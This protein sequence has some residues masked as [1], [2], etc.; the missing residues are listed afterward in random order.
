MSI[1][2]AE[3]T[4]RGELL[5]QAKQCVC[6]DRN[7]AYGPPEDSFNAIAA[8]WNT[9]LRGRFKDSD[10]R[11]HTV[12]VACLMMLLKIARLQ[13]NP[14]HWDS[15]VDIAGYA[16]CAGEMTIPVN[17]NEEP[18]LESLLRNFKET[19]NEVK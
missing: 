7:K 14:N 17:V 3:D 1:K 4:P 11:L 6:Q 15:K 19:G 2:L 10:I 13:E 5:Q 12:D 9:Y 16:A 8:L 18:G